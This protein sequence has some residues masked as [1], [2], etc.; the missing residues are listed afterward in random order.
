MD[1]KNLRIEDYDYKLPEE[2]TAKY[3]L[4][5]RTASKLLIYKN[6]AISTARF[7]EIDQYLNPQNLLIFNDTKVIQARL[8][9]QK[10][11]GAKLEIF[12]LE[13]YEPKDYDDNLKSLK[14][15]T[16]KCIV[17]NA[18]KWK[19]GDLFL[20][21]FWEGEKITLTAKK[22]ALEGDAYIIQFSWNHPSLSFAQILQNFGHIPIPPYLNR[23]AE[24]KDK[25]SYQTVYSLHGGSVAAPTAGLHFS[26]EILENLQKK[27]LRTGRITLHVGAGTFKPV[28]NNCIAEHVMHT[29]HFA[30]DKQLIDSILSNKGRIT[31]V[32]T[33]TVRTLESLYHLGV[34]ILRNPELDSLHLK[35]WEVYKNTSF[36]TLEES[37]KAILNYMDVNHLDQLKASTQI[38]ILPGYRFQMVDQ[39]LTNFH[40]PKST[41]IMLIAAFVGEDYRR[42]YD[43]AL[44]NNYRFLSYGDSSL[45]QRKEAINYD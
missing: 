20:S 45:L 38:M 14:I 43:F 13:P 9:F 33:T 40:Q 25:T 28:K 3:P 4:P 37:L 42:I 10:D 26:S 30:I 21:G 7:Y 12:C 15:C 17:G 34:K 22:I 6:G 36:P 32:G 18:R 27:G 29:E 31:A 39:L 5:D 16:W 44:H 35:Q 24:E 23:Q 19:Q 41:L 11:T 1:I 2:Q 8:F